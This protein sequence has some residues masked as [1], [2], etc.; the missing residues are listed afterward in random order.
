MGLVLVGG[1]SLGWWCGAE[2]Q[3]NLTTA[4]GQPSGQVVVPERLTAGDGGLSSSATV[5]PARPERPELPAQVRARLERFKLDARAY[6]AQQQALKKKMAG[7]KDQDRE[8]L[9][10]QLRALR[11]RWLEQAREMRQEQQA[12][13]Q[14][15]QQKLQGHKEL[16]D[17][18]RN[19]TI[20]Q[21]KQT[22]EHS[23]RGIE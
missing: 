11:E 7:A 4:A 3:T 22:T 20:E 21:N 9:R 18:I 15:L 13:K 5:R 19:N 2:A 10:E 23:R 1:V 12:Q 6:L 16:F 8:A 17:E 14:E